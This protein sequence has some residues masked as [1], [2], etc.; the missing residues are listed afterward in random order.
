MKRVKMV[1]LIGLAALGAVYAGTKP[2]DWTGKK[3]EIGFL[4]DVE[5]ETRPEDMTREQKNKLLVKVALGAISTGDWQS[6]EEL[7]SPRFIQHIPGNRGTISWEGFE[8]GCRMAKEFF[9]TQSY[10]IEDI[11]AE[12]DKVVVRLSSIATVTANKDKGYEFEKTIEMTEVDIF[13]IEAGR[14][15]E[16]WCEYDYTSVEGKLKAIMAGRMFR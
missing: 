11:I 13:R 9:N 4:M 3:E 14:I 16:E 2:E 1:V 5:M 7:Y 8:L 15:I 12:N 10:K 6:L